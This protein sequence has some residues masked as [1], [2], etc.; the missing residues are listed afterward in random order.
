MKNLESVRPC[1][2]LDVIHSG[3]MYL[4]HEQ[5][6]IGKEMK[7]QV[8]VGECERCGYM[9]SNKLCKACVLLEGLNRGLPKYQ[10]S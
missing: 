9:S 3:E 2:I 5:V 4:S 10:T 8:I 6:K 1:A 7:G